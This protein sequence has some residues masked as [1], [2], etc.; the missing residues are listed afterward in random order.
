MQ[1]MASSLLLQMQAAG[2]VVAEICGMLILNVPAKTSQRWFLANNA[3][4]WAQVN[5]FPPVCFRFNGSK[6][7]CPKLIGILT[8]LVFWDVERVVERAKSHL[9]DPVAD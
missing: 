9:L 1:V 8:Y 3:Q 5:N 7:L 6:M 4:R 2:H